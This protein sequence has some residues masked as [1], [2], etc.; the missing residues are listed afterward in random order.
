MTPERWRQIR[1]LFSSALRLEAAER[2]VFLDRNCSGDP[3]LRQ[4]VERLLAAQRDLPSSFLEPPATA[5]A[6]PF[7]SSASSSVLAP[8]TKLGPYALETLL[9]A[10]G[11]GEV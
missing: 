6:T 1:D 11:M 3:S 7:V 2:P 4:E 8:G 9:G 5:P 10:G